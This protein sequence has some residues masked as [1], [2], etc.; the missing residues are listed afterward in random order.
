MKFP[1]EL[2]RTSLVHGHMVVRDGVQA[3][4]SSNGLTTFHH[5]SI[6]MDKSTNSLIEVFSTGKSII[7]LENQAQVDETSLLKFGL[8]SIPIQQ[9]D[10]VAN[11]LPQVMSLWYLEFLDGHNRYYAFEARSQNEGLKFAIPAQMH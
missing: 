3:K 4:M 6:S 2:L 10:L 9:F 1:M 8:Y 7:Q 11:N 5:G